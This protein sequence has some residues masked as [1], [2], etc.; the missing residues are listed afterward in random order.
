MEFFMNVCRFDVHFT[1]TVD[2][3]GEGNPFKG[4]EYRQDNNNQQS[5]F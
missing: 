5:E 1:Q 2:T 3:F 4:S